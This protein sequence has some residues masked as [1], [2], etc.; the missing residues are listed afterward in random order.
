MTEASSRKRADFA[1]KPLVEAKEALL[2][3]SAPFLDVRPLGEF[4]AGH[5]TNAVRVPIEW[6]EA[7]AKLERTSLDNKHF[8]E[9]EIGALGLDGSR[10]ALIYDDGRLTEAARV[11]FILQY[12]GVPARVVNGGWPH[13]IRLPRQT[14]DA[15]VPA[16]VRFKTRSEAAQAGLA[17]REDVRLTVAGGQRIL[18]ARTT[19]EFEGQDL[20]G[21]ARG[22][23][24][25]GAAHLPH[26]RLLSAD[27]RLLP[28]AALR[29]IFFGAGFHPGDRVV[30]HC[31]GG[32]R[33]ALAAL[34]LL[35]A[36]FGDV[37]TYY[38]SF[39]DWAK[40]E[41]C[42]VVST[43]DRQAPQPTI[44]PDQDQLSLG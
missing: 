7:S 5:L 8:W 13:L 41:S 32:G 4:R 6:W 26:A 31:D 12:F 42:P 36:G 27:G 18:D 37:Q 40:D 11:W 3:G 10:T 22:G 23:H 43:P 28:A 35:E 1:V 30:T 19:A 17:E 14:G 20:R 24:L 44:S 38:L 16:T 29:D 33:A 2:F 39:A 25:P 9:A 15:A 21:N 34:A